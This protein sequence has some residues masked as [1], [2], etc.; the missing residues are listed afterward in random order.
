MSELH[1]T[2]AE[3]AFVR[4]LGTNTR[5]AMRATQAGRKAMLEQTAKLLQGYLRSLPFRSRR[6]YIDFRQ[7]ETAA[8]ERLRD[9]QRALLALN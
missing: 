2:D 8:T 4:G 3:I 5:A 9:V 6:E 7:V 1:T